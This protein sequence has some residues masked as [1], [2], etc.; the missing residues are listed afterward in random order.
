[1][2]F[3]VRYEHDLARN[4]TAPHVHQA[5]IVGVAPSFSVTRTTDTGTSA[6]RRRHLDHS[7]DH[8]SVSIILIAAVCPAY[9]HCHHTICISLGAPVCCFLPSCG[10]LDSHEMLVSGS[11]AGT[12]RAI[13][14]FLSHFRRGYQSCL[15]CTGELLWQSCRIA[16]SLPVIVPEEEGKRIDGTFNPF[17]T[18]C[19][20]SGQPVIGK[21]F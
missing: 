16:S 12:L 18:T 19:D 6:W 17:A 2:I 5:S 7:I 20:W 1:M 15:P 9:P 4:V 11:G 14:S 10:A 3:S 8:L 13:S 21:D